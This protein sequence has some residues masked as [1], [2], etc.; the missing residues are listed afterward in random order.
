MRYQN[1]SFGAAVVLC[2]AVTGCAAPG[3]EEDEVAA[4]EVEIEEPLAVT[5]DE[6]TL[7]HG[8]LRVAASM[9]EGSADV[10][11]WL[12]DSC[13]AQEVGRG[14]AT[15]SGFRWSLATDEVARAVACG[16]VVKA[17]GVN[18]E[19]QRVV[20]VASLD[21]GLSLEP[22]AA[23]T[24]SVMV[25]VSQDAETKVTFAV[26]RRASHIFVGG[27]VIG[28]EEEEDEAEP[29]QGMFASTFVIDDRDL[30]R[31]MLQ[32]RPVSVLGEYFLASVIVGGTILDVST[33][34]PAEPEQEPEPVAE[35]AEDYEE[36]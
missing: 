6:L 9:V 7:S 32:G 25:Q 28:A 14:I 24:V 13:E 30:A 1:V 17:H 33:P 22:E 31:A 27:T 16:L 2:L 21:V 26:P 35:V 20:K 8:S 3:P 23:E 11:V 36:G 18:A 10:A 19:G 29:P 4:P 12:G 15:P 34:A 5:V